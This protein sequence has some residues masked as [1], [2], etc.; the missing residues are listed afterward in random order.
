MPK[1]I[2]LAKLMSIMWLNYVSSGVNIQ[3]AMNGD[4]KKLTTDN[5]PSRSMGSAKKPIPYINSMVALAWL[6]KMLQ[7]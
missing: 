5:K 1:Q 2:T 3:H 4:E 6:S 7:T